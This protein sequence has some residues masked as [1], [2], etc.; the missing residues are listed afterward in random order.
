MTGLHKLWQPGSQAERKW[1]EN[2]KMKRKG[3]EN[4]EMERT[5]PISKLVLFCRKMLTLLGPGRGG[6]GHL[7][8]PIFHKA[9]SPLELEGQISKAATQGALSR[10]LHSKCFWWFRWIALALVVILRCVW[11]LWDFS[12]RTYE[13]LKNNIFS[14]AFCYWQ[15]FDLRQDWGEII[16]SQSLQTKPSHIFHFTHQL[17]YLMFS[18]EL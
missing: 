12:F 5:F 3:R 1:R 10:L 13:H 6:G 9:F 4:G 15:P 17:L 14:V 8:I 7:Q 2:Q 16:T 18:N 11:P